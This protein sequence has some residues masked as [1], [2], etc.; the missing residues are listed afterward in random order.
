[1]ILRLVRARVRRGRLPAVRA[2]LRGASIDVARSTDGLMRVHVGARET[3]AGHELLI[4]TT[5]ASA[6]AELSAL[7]GDVNRVLHVEG[8]SEHL[9][10][11]SVDHFEVDE[12]SIRESGADAT[13]LRAAAGWI[14]MGPDAEIQ[15]ELRRR[16]RELGEDLLEA[17]VGRRMRGKT[18]EVTFVTLWARAPDDRPLDEPLWPDITARYRS[19]S[20]ETFEPL[21]VGP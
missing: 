14:D 20:V 15:Q 2:G 6:E 5:W 11:E 12:S 8:V 19:F 13:V 3:D 1:M 21:L 10:V 16:M 7:G 9:D 17:Y 4:I 18:V